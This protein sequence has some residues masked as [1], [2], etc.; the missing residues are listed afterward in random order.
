MQGG[1]VIIQNQRGEISVKGV[2][3]SVN[4]ADEFIADIAEKEVIDNVGINNFQKTLHETK[5]PNEYPPG[6]IVMRKEGHGNSIASITVYKTTEK[7]Q[8]EKGWLSTKKTCK[9]EN[10]KLYT[11]SLYHA[12]M[13][14]VTSVMTNTQRVK[15]SIQGNENSQ[16]IHNMHCVFEELMR[17]RN[18]QIPIID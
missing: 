16:A 15:K 13:S 2:Y 8:E 6:C 10:E 7:V 3:G 1:V 5:H 17:K 9:V 11:V 12:D 4:N 18:L 14:N